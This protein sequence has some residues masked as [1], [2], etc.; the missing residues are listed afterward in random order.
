MIHSPLVLLSSVNL[1]Y[2]LTSFSSKPF[3]LVHSL[4]GATR[5]FSY[6]Y[7]NEVDFLPEIITIFI[8]AMGCQQ[9]ILQLNESSF[10][11]QSFI[12]VNAGSRHILLSSD[13]SSMEA[14]T[15]NM[16]FLDVPGT[17][18]SLKVTKTNNQDTFPV[19]SRSI[20]PSFVPVTSSAPSV[21]PIIVPRM[22]PSYVT[23][24]ETNQDNK[25]SNS[26]GNFT[27]GKFFTV[28]NKHKNTLNLNTNVNQHADIQVT[29]RSNYCF[30]R[31]SKSCS[32]Y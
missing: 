8:I 19:R 32:R 4:G 12:K 28:L 27:D 15:S 26:I 18:S 29:T 11:S 9:T 14:H 17:S 23:I 30:N 2:L 22:I 16:S 6:H 13:M 20:N 25:F 10:Q 1:L 21:D 31:W 24:L 3:T 5:R 7:A